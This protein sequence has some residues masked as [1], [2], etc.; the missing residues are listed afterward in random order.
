M[1]LGEILN[2]GSVPEWKSLYLDYKHGKKLIKR[3]DDIKEGVCDSSN[4]I[5]ND[6][7]SGKKTPRN[8]NES[9]P[10]LIPSKRATKYNQDRTESELD[11]SFESSP[12]VV[13]NEVDRENFQKNPKQD[14][15]LSPLVNS[16]SLRSN[17]NDDLEIEKRK[18]KNGLI[19]SWIK[20]THSTEKKKKVSLRSFSYCKIS[21]INCENIKP[22]YCEKDY[23][24][25]KNVIPL[26]MVLLI[27][28][29][30]YMM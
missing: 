7:N 26:C 5:E 29:T 25:I 14:D 21:Y 23:T 2:E 13:Y 18:F 3:L 15:N 8:A 6:I 28:T 30:A 11:S 1:R 12:N 19:L 17:K 20:S 22:W 10:L 9:T 27:P 24:N 16:C 4:S